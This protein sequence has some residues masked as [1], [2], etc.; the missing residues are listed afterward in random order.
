[1]RITHSGRSIAV[2]RPQGTGN[3]ETRGIHGNAQQPDDTGLAL[4]VMVRDACG[5]NQ[6]LECCSLIC[7]GIV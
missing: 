1:M 5:D 2:Q 4:A 7:R 3:R 6:V